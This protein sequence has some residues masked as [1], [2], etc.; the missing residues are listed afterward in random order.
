[1]TL[2]VGLGVVQHQ[3]AMSL[4]VGLVA[5]QHQGADS[6]AVGMMAV[7]VPLLVLLALALR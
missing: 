4:A 1:M 2:A 6:L 7:A 5:G 3:G